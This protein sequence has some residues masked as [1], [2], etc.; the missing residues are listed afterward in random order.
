MACVGGQSASDLRCRPTDEVSRVGAVD[1]KPNVRETQT[2]GF[3]AGWS[4]RRPQI[5]R[6][7]STV[8]ALRQDI[9]NHSYVSLV[10]SKRSNM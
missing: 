1:G 7:R 9:L 3:E 5:T 10:E 4:F 6:S 8:G 2:N